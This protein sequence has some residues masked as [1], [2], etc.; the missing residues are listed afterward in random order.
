MQALSYLQ[1]THVH[2]STFPPT[3][4]R[5][6]SALFPTPL[7]LPPPTN[8]QKS[9]SFL[10]SVLVSLFL[11]L[12]MIFGITY[13]CEIVFFL[14]YYNLGLC[15]FFLWN[16]VVWFSMNVVEF[17][18]FDRKTGMCFFWFDRWPLKLPIMWTF[19]LFFYFVQ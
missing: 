14:K 5:I 19:V 11:F 1:W 13:S 12:C 17:F 3:D 2:F 4:T 9:Y 7:S 15:L 10:R 18:T 8:R 16:F 6:H